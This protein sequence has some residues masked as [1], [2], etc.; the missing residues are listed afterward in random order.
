MKPYATDA[1]VD[2]MNVTA[3][4]LLDRYLPDGWRDRSYGDLLRASPSDWM[5]WMYPQYGAAQQPYPGMWIIARR[6]RASGATRGSALRRFAACSTARWRRL[7]IGRA[8]LGTTRPSARAKSATDA[9][10]AG[11]SAAMPSE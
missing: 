10:L 7:S 1:S 3:A 11:A 2:W 5:K 4:D 9:A 6:R 8:P